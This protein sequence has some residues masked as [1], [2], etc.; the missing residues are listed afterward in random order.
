MVPKVA[1]SNPV[2]HPF[3][4]MG[5]TMAK[6]IYRP[7]FDAATDSPLLTEYARKLDSFNGVLAD[8]KVELAELEDQEKRVVDLM[9]EVEPLLEPDVYEK[10]TELL[11]EITSYDMMS[12]FHLASKARAGRA[13]NSKNE[14]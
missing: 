10:V 2:I 11:C 13:L 5:L 12:A 4:L 8:R 14:S 7:W 6:P 1:G 3:P 9:K